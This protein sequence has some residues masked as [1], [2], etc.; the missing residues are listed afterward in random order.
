MHELVHVNFEGVMVEMLINIDPEQ[1]LKYART[2]R[3][4]I[5]VYASL[6]KVLYET[7]QY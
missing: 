2:E 6:Y 1:Y 3:G 5:V 4:K 7:L